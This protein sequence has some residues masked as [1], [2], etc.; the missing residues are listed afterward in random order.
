[1]S[2]HDVMSGH[3]DGGT[4][5]HVTRCY[6]YAKGATMRNFEESTS[7]FDSPLTSRDEDTSTG[8]HQVIQPYSREPLSDKKQI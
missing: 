8:R 7:E 5:L 1:M 3:A 2:D 4:V 6:Q